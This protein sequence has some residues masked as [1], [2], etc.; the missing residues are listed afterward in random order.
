MLSFE[1]GY[2]SSIKGGSCKRVGDRSEGFGEIKARAMCVYPA[3]ISTPSLVGN[4][5]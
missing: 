2:V 5:T 3:I 4:S 1:L